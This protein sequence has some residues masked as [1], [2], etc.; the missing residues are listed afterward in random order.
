M[1]QKVICYVSLK[2][3]WAIDFFPTSA[4]IGLNFILGEILN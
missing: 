1:D 3:N 4:Q 2:Y